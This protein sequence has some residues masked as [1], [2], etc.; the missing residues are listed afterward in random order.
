MNDFFSNIKLVSARIQSI[1]IHSIHFHGFK[2]HIKKILIHSR[3]L[4]I[5]KED[6]FSLEIRR[7]RNMQ[8]SKLLDK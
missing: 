6:S 8:V 3:L 5:E 2:I 7:N 4:S 1:S